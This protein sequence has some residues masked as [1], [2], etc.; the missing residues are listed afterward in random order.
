MGTVLMVKFKAFIYRF[1][2]I[3][4]LRLYL[5]NKEEAGHL[6]SLGKKIKNKNDKNI[7]TGLWQAKHGFTTVGTYNKPFHKALIAKIKHAFDFR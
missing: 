7:Y 1:S 5:A 4:G 3:F 2:A 6:K